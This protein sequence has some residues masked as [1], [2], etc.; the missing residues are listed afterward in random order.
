MNKI[1]RAVLASSLLFSICGCGLDPKVTERHT[2]PSDAKPIDW[3]PGSAIASNGPV[4]TFTAAS[5]CGSDTA[6]F[7]SELLMGVSPG[8]SK[9][10]YEWADI[11][12]G[13]KQM[14]IAGSV[15]HTHLGPQDLPL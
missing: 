7:L 4:P 10:N 5:V 14:R 9:V 13:G 11:V 8:D 15:Q 2:T 6:T 1:A 3:T 12:P